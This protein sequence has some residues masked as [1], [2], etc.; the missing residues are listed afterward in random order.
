MERSKQFLT[1][2]AATNYRVNNSKYL[3]T[4]K[5]INTLNWNKLVVASGTMQRWCANQCWQTLINS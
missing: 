5:A 4:S 1:K 3:E 2:Q